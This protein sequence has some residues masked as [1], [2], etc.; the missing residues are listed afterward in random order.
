MIDMRLHNEGVSNPY[1]L[2]DTSMLDEA[3]EVVTELKA[4]QR[5]QNRI[6]RE[7]G[8]ENKKVNPLIDR[9]MDIS[10]IKNLF[11]DQN[12]QTVLADNLGK[13]L[14]VW[15]TNFF[16]KKEGTGD[17]KWHHDRHFENGDDPIDIFNTNNH[18]TFLVALT[19]IDTNA[20]R[21]EYLKGTHRPIPGFSRDIPRHFQET[22]AIVQNRVAPLLFKRGQFVVFYSSLIH[23]SLAFGEGDGRI[24]MAARLARVGTI[25]PGY[26]ASNPAGGAQSEAEPIVYYQESGIL[27]VN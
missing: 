7:A 10:V 22:P 27:P 11:F 3:C 24:S 19:D 18:F 17:N 20:G 21:I 16:V 4:R 14:F 23:R 12:V 25:F 15:R 6:A 2:A 1:E 26:G 8:I 13:D 9:H 5:E